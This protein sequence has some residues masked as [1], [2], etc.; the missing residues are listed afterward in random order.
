M[1]RSFV[2]TSIFAS[3][4]AAALACGNASTSGGPVAEKQVS[5]PSHVMARPLSPPAAARLGGL[6]QKHG[7]RRG[8][9]PA[10]RPAL[11]AA[12]I[13]ARYQAFA[14]AFDLDARVAGT[15]GA[16]VALIENGRVTFTHGYGTAGINS[17]APVDENTI[18]RVGTMTQPLTAAAELSLIDHGTGALGETVASAVPNVALSGPYAASVTMG[19]LLSNQS[20]LYDFTTLS[21][22][23]ALATYSCATDPSTLGSFVTGAL[24]GQNEL[25]AT[26]P[27]AIYTISNPNFIL[28]GAAIEHQTGAFFT[29]A[30]NRTLFAPL[31]MTRTFFLPTDVTAAGNYADGTAYDDTGNLADVAPSDYDCA[32]YRPYGYA[33]SSVS[34][35]ARFVQ[36]LINGNP[37]VLSEASRVAMESAQA[38]TR[39]LGRISAEGYGLT[40]AKGYLTQSNVYYPTK[41]VSSV[42]QIDGYLSSFYAL[43]ETGFGIVILA[44]FGSASFVN[45][46]DV[47]VRGFAKLPPAAPLPAGTFAVPA[48]LARYVGTYEDPTGYLGRIVVSDNAGALTVDFPDAPSLGY[49]FWPQLSPV[50]DDSFLVTFGGDPNVL[51]LLPDERGEFK[52]LLIDDAIPAV[53]LPPEETTVAPD[54][55]Q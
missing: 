5:A 33:F 18:F 53:R 24:F 51:E 34:D 54:A 42:G 1:K 12:A 2:T 3:M 37:R 4:T 35:Y 45:S 19:Q 22:D 26:P 40:V 50:L 9:R 44:N 23:P 49:T 8:R 28:T 30:M 31:G 27:G 21:A 36:L 55:G 17:T 32:A 11:A 16:A 41:T 20:G 7:M 29:E 25:F 46:T 43:P 38:E 13:P 48:K 47:A 10:A 15:P 52:Y 6:P 39:D 14:A